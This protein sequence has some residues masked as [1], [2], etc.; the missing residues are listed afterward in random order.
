M[1][2]AASA[3][4]RLEP[5]HVVG[6]AELRCERRAA[7]VGRQSSRVGCQ[8]RRVGAHANDLRR[9][10][11]ARPSRAQLAGSRGADGTGSTRELERACATN[12]CTAT[13]VKLPARPQRSTSAVSVDRVNYMDLRT[14][15]KAT[16]FATLPCTKKVHP[17]D[18][19]EE[20]TA[21]ALIWRIRVPKQLFEILVERFV[22][23]RFVPCGGTFEA[24]QHSALLTHTRLFV[25][26]M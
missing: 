24:T 2:A 22:T 5:V 17:H 19:R 18:P 12:C 10:E 3:R 16:H 15:D 13:W 21:H 4:G 26:R 7:R 1:P 23:V 9:Q 20:C 14:G 8:P 11:D 25:R 6:A